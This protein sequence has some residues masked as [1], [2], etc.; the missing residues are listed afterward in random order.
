MSS[1]VKPPLVH[2]NLSSMA[3]SFVESSTGERPR[4]PHEHSRPTAT[5]WRWR[6]NKVTGMTN[7]GMLDEDTHKESMNVES[8][9]TREGEPFEDTENG[10]HCRR[11]MVKVDDGSLAVELAKMG[12]NE[13]KTQER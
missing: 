3:T 5:L 7:G 13:K 10:A 9:L 12:V 4:P 11:V 2:L 1:V 8:E 6:L